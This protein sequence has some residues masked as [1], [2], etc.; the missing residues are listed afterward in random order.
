MANEEDVDEFEAVFKCKF[1]LELL[2]LWLFATKDDCVWFE[3]LPNDVAKLVAVLELLPVDIISIGVGVKLVPSECNSLRKLE[4]D[5]AWF[6]ADEKGFLVESFAVVEEEILPCKFAA[7]EDCENGI[8][9]EELL[10]ERF[11]T[12]LECS[13]AKGFEAL[14]EEEEIVAERWLLLGWELEELLRALISLFLD[15]LEDLSRE[16]RDENEE[17]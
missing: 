1:A 10:V 8:L 5:W 11:C 13:A 2:L 17:E 3:F 12:P 4:D 6:V 7:D 9:L 16:S 15:D 14:N